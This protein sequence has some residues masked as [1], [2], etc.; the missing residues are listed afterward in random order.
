MLKM[1]AGHS[2]DNAELSLERRCGFRGVVAK[3]FKQKTDAL[4]ERV[5]LVELS[6]AFKAQYPVK[7]FSSDNTS[8]WRDPN[9]LVMNGG[10]HRGPRDFHHEVPMVPECF[11][12]SL[13]PVVA[14]PEDMM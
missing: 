12:V 9:H 14:C 4:F 11:R 10:V 3:E 1:G 2:I 13:V 8:R 6:C 5:V 7:N